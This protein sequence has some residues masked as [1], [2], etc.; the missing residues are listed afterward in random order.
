M[1]SASDGET[2]EEFVRR[3]ESGVEQQ[4]RAAQERG[5]FDGLAGHG[6]PIADLDVARPPG[7]WATAWV[8]GERA[9]MAHEAIE[10]ARRDL[11]RAILRAADTD[12][13][14]RLVEAFNEQVTRHNERVDAALRRTPGTAGSAPRTSLRR[15]ELANVHQEI[16]R[17]YRH[18]R[19]QRSRARRSGW[20]FAGR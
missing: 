13:I 10:D 16:D 12:E 1:S 14:R 7:W 11:G 5:E 15:A 9:G 6:E 2:S 4:I 8:E 17:W 18:R 19:F 3:F 20:G